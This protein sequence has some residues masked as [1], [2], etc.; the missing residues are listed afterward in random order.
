[1][2]PSHVNSSKKSVVEGPELALGP[3]IKPRLRG[4]VKWSSFL[5]QPSTGPDIKPL[6]AGGGSPTGGAF[7]G[8]EG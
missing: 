7:S 5:V 4:S 2:S 6:S 8:G 1:M 3:D